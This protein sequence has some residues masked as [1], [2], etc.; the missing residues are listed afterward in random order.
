MTTA[1]DRPGVRTG[2]RPLAGL[3]VLVVAPFPYPVDRGSPLRAR[4]LVELATRA[5]AEVHVVTYGA[6]LPDAPGVRRG[7]LGLRIDRAGFT[8]R[9]LPADADLLQAAVRA[10]R[11]V[12]PQV[13]EGHV[14]EG[15]ALSLLTRRLAAPHA[16]VVYNAHGTL[17]DEL[18]HSGHAPYGSQRHR[19]AARVERRLVR[20]ADAVLAQSQH[21][22]DDVARCRGGSADVHVLPDAPEPGLFPATPDPRWSGDPRPLAVYTGSMEDYQ[23]VPEVLRAAEL[24]PEVRYVLFG[25]PAGAVVEAVRARGLLGNVTVVDPAPYGELPGLLA[26]ADVALAPRRYGGNIPGKVP[27]YLQAGLPVVGTRVPGLTELVDDAVGALV[28]VGD[29]EGLAAAVR[30]MTG[31][32]RPRGI[33]AAARARV[34]GR[35]GDGALLGALVPA[36]RG[37]V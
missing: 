26:A 2:L 35:Y 37:S 17:A 34:E 30:R 10:A 22:A 9:K 8:W 24:T 23:G 1:L 27:A 11:E 6:G 28:E 14:H 25:G 29:A 20:A 16:R 32:E 15:L 18:A 7:R 12:R 13:I 36:Y 5:G 4:R 3:R 19:A 21:R 31:P 33:G